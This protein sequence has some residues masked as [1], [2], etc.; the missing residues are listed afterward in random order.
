MS[1]MSGLDIL[2]IVAVVIGIV[3][4]GL[5]FL[6]RWSYKKMNQQETLIEKTKAPATIYVIDKKKTKASEANLPKA[7]VQQLPKIYKFMKMHLVKA[8]VGPQVVTLMCE[9]KIF[10]AIPVKK[11]VKVELAGIYIVSVKGMK[12]EK[13]LKAARAAKKAQREK[14]EGGFMD[15]AKGM[16]GKLPFG[17]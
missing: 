11:T 4:V 16:I 10:E 15:K 7:V 12:T 2:L 3:I 8:K 1:S 6:N 13:E 17:K 5:Y 14:S 9:K